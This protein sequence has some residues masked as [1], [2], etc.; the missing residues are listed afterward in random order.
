[1]ELELEFAL[2]AL[3]L[4]ADLA[5]A[6]CPV[7]SR[8][9]FWDSGSGSGFE[10]E[11]ELVLEFGCFCVLV[12]ACSALSR[13]VVLATEKS[14]MIVCCSYGCFVFEIYQDKERKK[15]RTQ[16]GF[17]NLKFKFP[18]KSGERETGVRG[19]KKK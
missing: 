19:R 1:M 3:F 8:N 11:F 14:G 17:Q 7:K 10:F 15:E 12:P 13:L 6:S 18:F 2:A 9:G 5:S 16:R 4:A